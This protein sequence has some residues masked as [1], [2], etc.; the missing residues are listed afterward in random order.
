MTSREKIEEAV[1]FNPRAQ[2]DG[3]PAVSAGHHALRRAGLDWEKASVAE[4]HECLTREGASPERIA[5]ECRA[6]EAFLQRNTKP[7]AYADAKFAHW[8]ANEQAGILAPQ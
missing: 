7:A 6:R 2:M 3:N 4:L 1:S 8:L 5:S